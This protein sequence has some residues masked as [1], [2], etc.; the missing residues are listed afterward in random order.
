MDK[1]YDNSNFVLLKE[2][3]QVYIIVSNLGYDINKFQQEVLALF[4]RVKISKVT[5]LQNALA[6]NVKGLIQIGFL[7]P[8]CALSVSADGLYA[9]GELALTEEEFLRVDMNELRDCIENNFKNKGI[10]FGAIELSKEDLQLHHKFIVAAGQPPVHGKDAVVK[11][12][13]METVQPKLEGTG[14]VD[15]YELSII[16]RILKDG[17]LGERIEPT[18]GIDGISV[19]NTVIPSTTGNQIPLKYDPKTVAQVYNEELNCTQLIAKCDGAIVYVNDL[20]SVQNT[21]EVDGDVGYST[22]NIDFNGFVDIKGSIDDNFSVIADENIQILGDMGVGAIELIESRKGDIYIRSG[23]AGKHKAVLR[24]K[25]NIYLKFASDCT[26][27]AEGSV[28]IGYYAI[29]CTILA[30]DI[31]FESP[32]SRLIGGEAIAQIKVNVSEIGSKSAPKTVV[33]I[34]GFERERLQ[35][36]YDTI[37]E[38]IKLL[39]DKSQRTQE[40]TAEK[41]KKLLAVKATYSSYLKVKGQGEI[42]AKNKVYP[43]VTLSIRD[44]NMVVSEEKKLGLHVYYENDQIITL[45]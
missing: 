17:W 6:G 27:I 1:F 32:T 25:G 16:N 13:E 34:K 29:N 40:K 44:K 42:V 41:L 11:M 15:H 30:K 3:D 9:Y 18:A 22:G 14:I 35:H 5:A 19:Y 31:S 7:A 37:N 43:N 38:G 28:N 12:Y 39:S 45:N 2:D 26:I 20:I 4:P 21:I 23:I 33:Q 36:E 24:A 10:S 8:L